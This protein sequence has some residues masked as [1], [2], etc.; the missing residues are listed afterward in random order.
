MIKEEHTGVRI[1]KYYDRVTVYP[2]LP[3][4]RRGTGYFDGEKFV[5][6]EKK[7]EN[8]KKVEAARYRYARQMISDTVKCMAKNGGIFFTVTSAGAP[9]IQPRKIARLIEHMK[10]VY[11]LIYYTWVRENTKSG[12]PHWHFAAV[13]TRRGMAWINWMRQKDPA[14]G[15][16]RIEA[17]S[18]WWAEL[19]FVKSHS[20]SI[21]LGWWYRNGRP[22]K[23]FLDFKAA[24]YLVKY[25]MKGQNG[26]KKGV[27]KW[28]TNLDYLRPCRFDVIRQTSYCFVPSKRNII[29]RP[30]EKDADY[31]ARYYE[32]LYFNKDILHRSRCDTVGNGSYWA[33][34]YHIKP[35]KID[36]RKLKKYI[37]STCN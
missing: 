13:F 36:L 24:G 31:F 23:F 1:I 2:Y 19:N 26:Q 16:T 25:L 12:L 11:G 3:G 14:T 18:D 33:R 8:R 27:R 4:S 9:D 6:A 7:V 32:Q 37:E 22:T 30:V 17:L 21:R 35:Q 20:N 28:T 5:S 29:F 10:R 34:I 15:K